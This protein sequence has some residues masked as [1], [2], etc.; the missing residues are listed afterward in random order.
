LCLNK[1]KDSYPIVYNSEVDYWK[2][3]KEAYVGL[4]NYEAIAAPIASR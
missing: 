1:F 4:E 2:M 3:A